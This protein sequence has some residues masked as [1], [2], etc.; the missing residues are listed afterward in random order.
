M[1][2]GILVS[3]GSFN[4]GCGIGPLNES[5]VRLMDWAL[6]K[7]LKLMNTSFKKNICWLAKYISSHAGAVDYILVNGRY[8]S[9]VRDVKVISGVALVSLRWLSVMV[10]LLTTE[11]RRKWFKTKIKL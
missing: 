4:G 6:G 3:S 1:K 8:R 9:G 10:V 7:G 5:G 11:V 2:L